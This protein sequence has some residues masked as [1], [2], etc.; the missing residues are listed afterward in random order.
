MVEQ[1]HYTP[2]AK[3]DAR[4]IQ[5]QLEESGLPGE[6]IFRQVDHFILARDSKRIAGSPRPGSLRGIWICPVAGG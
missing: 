2:A 4:A 5:L 3:S 1:I 6:D